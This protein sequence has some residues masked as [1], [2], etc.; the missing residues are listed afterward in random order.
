[1]SKEQALGDIDKDLARLDK[2]TRKTDHDLVV[3][4][5]WII[6]LTGVMILV[7]IIQLMVMWPKRT[8]CFGATDKVQICEPDYFPYDSNPTDA[9]YQIDKQLGS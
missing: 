7:G 4:T 3:L 9:A 5:K 2:D 8:Y 6:I 1:M